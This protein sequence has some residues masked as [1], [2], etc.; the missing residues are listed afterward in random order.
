MRR[1]N[2]VFSMVS[3]LWALLMVSFNGLV[4]IYQYLQ[5]IFPAWLRKSLQNLVNIAW[6]NPLT[7]LRSPNWIH[8]WRFYK[9]KLM[10]KHFYNK[11]P[12]SCFRNTQRVFDVLS[13]FLSW[14]VPF[15][16]YTLPTLY[17][18]GV[19]FPFYGCKTLLY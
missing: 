14:D 3:N 9:R 19:P 15:H 8:L 6:Q 1:Q 13:Y 11:N 18:K 10:S 5:I 12:S 16:K 7:F 4:C 17:R 2:I